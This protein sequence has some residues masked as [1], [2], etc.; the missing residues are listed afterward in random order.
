MWIIEE[1][2]FWHYVIF[3]AFIIFQIIFGVTLNGNPFF[4]KVIT[5]KKQPVRFICTIVFQIIAVFVL[6]FV[7]YNLDMCI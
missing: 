6:P 5:R 3:T 4:M 7:M 2:F 1:G